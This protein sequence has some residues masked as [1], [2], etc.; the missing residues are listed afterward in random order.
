MR[1][2]TVEVEGFGP[3][4]SRQLIDFDAFASD[5]IFLIGGRTGAGKTSI[6]DAVCFALYGSAPRY[7][8]G[9]PRLRSDHVGPDE[10]TRVTLVFEVGGTEY[11]ITRTPDY[12]RPKAR[13]EGLTLQKA[14]A[15]LS[16]RH[17]DG[18]WEGIA[19]RPVDVAAQIERIVQLTRDQFL[20]VILLAQNRFHEFL[21]AESENRQ[22]L[23]RTLFGTRRFDEY[24]QQLQERRKA[25]DEQLRDAGRDL[26][27]LV[28]QL[29]ELV[30]AE[31][32]S[33]TN[34]LPGWAGTGVAEL[35]R[36][37]AEADAARI[38]AVAA[39][40]AASA[41]HEA[42]AQTAERQ[43]RRAEGVARL[44]VAEDRVSAVEP[45]RGELDAADRAAAVAPFRAESMR[46]R[47]A[48]ERA[49]LALET[50]TDGYPGD[51]AADLA[52]VLSDT[53]QRLGVLAPLVE[54]EGRIDALARDVTQ[55]E[56]ALTAHDERTAGFET[57]LAGI[58]ERR[59]SIEADET[60]ARDAAAPGAAAQQTVD[61]STAALAAA[62]RAAR[63]DTEL[64]EALTAA[65]RASEARESAATRA[66]E[67]R[68]RRLDGQAATLAH[69]LVPGE[70]CPVCGSA[71][72]PA[73]ATWDGEPVT[74]DDVDA[75]E[76]ALERASATVTTADARTAELRS[77]LAKQRGLANEKTAEVLRAELAEA[78]ARVESARAAEARLAALLAER[79]TLDADE[80]RIH[81][82][83]AS[84]SAHR[85]TLVAERAAAT[86]RLE[87]AVTQVT[88]GRGEA[89]SIAAL[90]SGLQ[91]LKTATQRLI[92]A[93]D[94]CAEAERAA[95]TAETAYGDQ[96]GAHRFDDDD[97]VVAATR[98]DVER[99]RMRT[100]LERADVEL[101]TVKAL[102]EAP[103]LRDLP[104][105]PVDLTEVTAARN[106]ANDVRDEATKAHARQAD[107]AARATDLCAR[108]L[109]EHAS[110]GELAERADV[111]R[112]LAAT[113]RGLPPNTYGMRLESFVLAAELEQIVDAANVRLA[114]MSG[115]RYL[116]EHTDQR[117][118]KRG[119][120]GLD[121][122]VIDQHTGVARPPRSLSGGETFLAS[123]ALA[124]GLAEVVTARAGGIRLDTLFIDEGFGS[125]DAD[126]LEVAMHTLDGL[127]QGGR[128][129]GLISH[130]EAMKEQIPSQLRVDVVEGGW[131]VIRQSV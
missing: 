131:S 8:G 126:T 45:L 75:A 34:E 101:A 61:I 41:A 115:G 49:R 88:E 65:L 67:L 47:D 3:F 2:L 128:T 42:A 63:L 37:A 107:A 83:Q 87:Q 69:E 40:E 23:L 19:A 29:G 95:I 7:D 70:P 68:R 4:K 98:T 56:L 22:K 85:E 76:S 106:A 46:A 89:E 80:A 36:A 100:D 94:A 117:E 14:T 55:A 99:A 72:H 77:E 120:A 13:G 130:V 97:A 93:R 114:A 112:T 71:E 109:R 118:Q 53:D 39:A 60:A 122:A 27:S 5:G 20:Q 129:I 116:L 25:V 6:L 54:L 102:L 121:L 79:E 78:R 26:D 16:V 24:D 1:I 10:P 64:A 48:A 92:D 57:Q 91:S 74:D 84:A 127:R 105:E 33:A 81:S 31:A 62:E 12:Q 28:A 124:L 104:A 113:V 73:P 123:L 86:T 50:A 21:L 66:T 35:V 125:L 11:R 44:A 38:E 111:I 90:V 59:A 17:A 119:Q 103:E 30:E 96:R 82:E 18:A 9:S 15:E 108:L 110:V 43:R 32:P 58:R 51:A 52:A